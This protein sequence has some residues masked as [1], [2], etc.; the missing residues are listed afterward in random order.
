MNISDITAEGFVNTD[1]L[2]NTLVHIINEKKDSEKSPLS[3]IDTRLFV[4]KFMDNYEKHF[5]KSIN[6]CY[7]DTYKSIFSDIAAGLE[8]NKD[9]VYDT[10]ATDG[11]SAKPATASK[12][13]SP[14]EIIDF[15]KPE[16]RKDLNIR[17]PE[18]DEIYC[19]SSNGNI[20][21]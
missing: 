4:K 8:E 15:F 17:G 2:E 1:R 20:V 14:E 7:L 11:A 6:D 18:G 19:D 5:M 12:I 13:I 3:Y 9:K 16:V 10:D 21:C